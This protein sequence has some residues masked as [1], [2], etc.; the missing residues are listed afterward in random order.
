[1][2]L[3]L[4]A[5]PPDGPAH[6]ARQVFRYTTG[7]DVLEQRPST[8]HATSAFMWQAPEYQDSYVFCAI[9]IRNR[10]LPVIAESR[11]G[12]RVGR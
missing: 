2:L 6:A 10:R 5:P 8:D 3:L 4:T 9:A 11:G 7:S 12:R 1:M